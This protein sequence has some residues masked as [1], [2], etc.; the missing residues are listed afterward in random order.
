MSKNR[1]SEETSPYLLQH[2]NNPV[3]WFG[4]GPEAIEAAK[5]QDKPILL[6]VGYAACHWCHV[7]AHESF[8]DEAIAGQMN[9]LYINVK[10][11]REERPDIDTIYQHA[12][13]LLDQQGGWPLTMFLT[14]D[15]EPFWGG[16]YFPP[17]SRYGRPGF[18]QVLSAISDY[19]IEQRDKAMESVDALKSGLAKVWTPEA[20][21]GAGKAIALSVN[22]QVSSR[23]A[24]E[25]DMVHG[26]LG[27]S[28]KFPNP[29]IHE[30]LWRSWL[31]TGNETQR[32]AVLF[33]LTK[34]SQGGIYDHLGG[35]YAR[36]STDSM[37][38]APHFEKMLYD[39]AQIVDLLTWAWQETKNPL[40]AQRVTE[41]IEWCLR[42]MIAPVDDVA[43]KPFAATYDADSEGIEGKFYVWSAAEVSEILGG[44]ADAVLFNTVYNVSPE[45]NWEGSNI[46]NRIAHP[47]LL[48]DAQEDQLKACREKLLAVRGKRIWPGWDDKI[49]ADWNGLMIAAIA[50]AARV[51]DRPD[52][53]DAAHSAF[54]FVRDRMQEDVDG[55]LRLKHSFRAGKLK[56]SAPLDDY[57]NMSRAAIALYEATG[58]GAYVDI[59][60]DWIDVIDTH[61]WDEDGGGYFFTAD[62]AEALIIRTKSAADNATPAGNSVIAAVLA[63]MHFLTG[64]DHFRERAEC[65]IS[66][67]AGEAT[68]NFYPLTGLFCANE[69]LQTC[70]QV[71]IVGSSEDPDTMALLDVAWKASNMNKLIQAIPANAVL[72]KNHPAAGKGQ[73]DGRATAYVCIGQTCSLPL[74]DP[75]ALAL[76]L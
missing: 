31:R 34:M 32:D 59:A 2:A 28:P 3:H 13:Q 27:Q 16:T 17:D 67:F 14:P 49:L 56:H 15:G 1:L 55:T 24:H 36:Y 74:A 52:W 45:G 73:R 61:Y 70:A 6:S 42:E 53:L 58:I 43:G 18:P 33:S 26:G 41:T 37:W 65:I 25:F 51:F 10:V 50:N 48:D 60:I 54:A 21:T 72:P 68:Q 46:L 5:A 9:D 64:I 69:L 29:S 22:D 75:D 76:T 40:F 47:E 7:M 44:G 66:T 23:L 19:W 63:R 30:L 4:W 20:V 39:N 71:V 12:L 57:A 11:D 35:G 38:L 8:E 62:D